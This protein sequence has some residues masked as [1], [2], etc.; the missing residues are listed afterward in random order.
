MDQ[1][2]NITDRMRCCVLM[3]DSHALRSSF[4]TTCR[5]SAA[6]FNQCLLGQE[7]CD[8]ISASTC[9]QTAAAPRWII[10]IIFRP[11]VVLLAALLLC[12]MDKRKLIAYVFIT[13][14]S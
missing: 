2:D 6:A 5:S 7:R 10:G 13:A 4:Q 1:L 9:R 11:D 14:W 3:S 12:F 8:F